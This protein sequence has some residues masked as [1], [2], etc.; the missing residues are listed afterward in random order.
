M[1][2]TY[3]LLAV[4]IIFLIPAGLLIRLNTVVKA[5]VE[6]LPTI[7]IDTVVQTGFSSPVGIYHSGDGTGRLFIVEQVGKIKIIKNGAVL[8]TPFLSLDP[9]TQVLSGGERGLLGL[10]F[11]PNFESNG[12]FYIN[13]TRQPDGAT[14]IARYQVSA[15]PDIAN[16]GSGVALLTIGQPYANHNGGHIAF[17]KDGYLYIGMGDGGSA[18]DPQNNAQ[19]MNTLLGKMLRIDVDSTSPG[20]LYALPPGNLKDEI[21]AVGLRNPWFW[22]FD[23]IY[24]DI[25]IADVGQA[26]W[27]EVDFRSFTDLPGANFG[28]SCL[29]GNHNSNLSRYPCNVP[30]FVA[31]TIRPIAEYSHSEGQS[32]TGGFIYRGNLYPNLTGLYFYADFSTGKIW[33]LQQTSRNPITFSN[34]YLHLDSNLLISCFGEDENGELYLCDY[35]GGSI[36]KLEDS[37]GAAPNLAGSTFLSEPVYANQNEIMTY[38]LTLLN[39]GGIST[40][41]VTAVIDI[42]PGLSYI[43]STGSVDDS[44]APRLVWEGILTPNVPEVITY[45]VK[46]DLPSGNPY[47]PVQVSGVGY[48]ALTLEHV[49]L[50]PKPVLQTTSSDFF[51]PGTQPGSLVDPIVLHVSCDICHTAMIYDAWQG[52]MM[53][54]AARDPLFWAA[55]E[56][57]NHDAP[58]SG[59]Y[60]IRCHTPKAWL[61]GRSFAS[62]GSAL[63]QADFDSGVS[64]EACHRAIDPVDSTNP[65]DQ[66]R[67]RDAAI[68]SQIN[69]GLPSDHAGSM[70]MIF[71]PEDYRRGPFDLGVNFSYHPNQ[72]Y[73][74]D[75]LGGDQFNP[76]ARSRLCGSCHNV[77]NPILSWNTTS[78]EYLPNAVNAPAPSFAQDA[79]FAVETTFDEWLNSDYASTTACQ[80]CHMPRS[81]GFAA[82]EFF[83][84]V[85]R[86]CGING[87]LPVHEFVGGNTWIPQLLQDSLW[88]LNRQDL[89]TLLT[90]TIHKARAMLHRAAR[91]NV[92]FQPGSGEVGVKVTN[93]TGHKLP[94]GYSEG[95][96]MWLHV[97]A[98]D[99]AGNE[100]YSTCEYDPLSGM[101]TVDPDCI[102]FE[103]QQAIS[104]SMSS[105]LNSTIP[106]GPSFHFVLNN[107]VFKDN[108]I[109]PKGFNAAAFS[110]PGL[111]PM[112]NG[113]PSTIYVPGQNYFEKTYTLPV[114]AVRVQAFLY[115]QTASKEY[116][117]F[118]A[119]KGGVDARTLS[120][121][122]TT[123]K[124]QPELMTWDAFPIFS[125]HFPAIQH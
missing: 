39:Q 111:M 32:I 55:V 72:T 76:L 43:D 15:N 95:R 31:K 110:R 3:C 26:S 56:V 113:Q 99:A 97:V 119:A 124:S 83:N 115:Y 78:N 92:T 27:E 13:Y 44:G 90:Q 116:I 96:R 77:D 50:I 84:P 29:E 47:T 2:K 60:C 34:P 46:V 107:S 41:P 98:F 16:P 4:L 5:E 33:S 93:L 40:N 94:T 89:Q 49:L 79:L 81:T 68:R 123:D 21:W 101:L 53:G 42:P 66:A 112:E 35:R 122:W 71:D 8:P 54:Q 82:E 63:T 57:A 25:F 20:R 91:V 64:C 9:A 74:S 61:E 11:H 10:A 6:V 102:V 73:R 87:C 104:P 36:R 103:I 75:F 30:E 58:G 88:R 117:D 106:A 18:G 48:P 51:F 22:S 23:R 120:L 85:L 17:G 118:L 28:W 100:V 45:T 7:V 114:A 12:L 38:T 37:S 80:D 14:V 24:G 19:N 108:R 62:D 59:E 70:M 52:S 65:N 69:P 1:K 121:L 109:P 86:D 67:I 105:V 125:Y